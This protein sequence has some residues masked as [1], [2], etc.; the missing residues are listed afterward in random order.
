MLG[1]LTRELHGRSLLSPRPKIPFDGVSFIVLCS[2]I[3]S[4]KSQKWQGYP[5]QKSSIYL[6]S[7]SKSGGTQHNCR[8]K[9]HVVGVI[10]R[11]SL[12][13]AGLSLRDMQEPKKPTT[14]GS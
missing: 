11:V 7:P 1:A 12:T 13:V 8:L 14:E 4:M 5:S 2:Q 9:T 3:W 10:N 6:N